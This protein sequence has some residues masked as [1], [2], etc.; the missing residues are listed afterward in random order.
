M[1]IFEYLNIPTHQPLYFSDEKFYA[2]GGV[3]LNCDTGE[4]ITLNNEETLAQQLKITKFP[5]RILNNRGNKIYFENSNGY[6]EKTE[7]GANGKLSRYETSGGYWETRE[8]DA[9]G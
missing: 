4:V 1:T 2:Y 9:E 3:L 5:F 7:Y 8:Y 6:W